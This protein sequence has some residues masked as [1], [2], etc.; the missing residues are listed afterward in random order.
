MKKMIILLLLLLASTPAF[1]AHQ[2]ASD[3]TGV[4]V[5]SY[6]VP[7]VGHAVTVHHEET[8]RTIT[9][10]TNKKGRYHFANL[11]SDGTYHVLAA[12]THYTGRLL[13]G[14]VHR[15]NFVSGGVVA[16]SPA[17]LSSWIWT[18]PGQRT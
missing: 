2:L 14:K 13:L 15:Q 6:G 7:L 17:Y 4:V 18:G 1:A 10:Y 5:D 8:N 12:N 16:G 11:R 3:I 9:R